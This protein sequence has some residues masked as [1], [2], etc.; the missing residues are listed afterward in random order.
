MDIDPQF[1]GL[2]KRRWGQRGRIGRKSISSESGAQ[3]APGA[4]RS[5]EHRRRC[6]ELCDA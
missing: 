1:G 2:E 5:V 6:D 4:G 3:A